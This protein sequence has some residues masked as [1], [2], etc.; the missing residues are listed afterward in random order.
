MVGFNIFSGSDWLKLFNK[1]LLAPMIGLSWIIYFIENIF[2]ALV[3]GF[4]DAKGNQMDI[5]DVILKGEAVQKIVLGLMIAGALLLFVFALIGLIKQYTNSREEANNKQVMA[6]AFKGFM[7]MLAIPLVVIGLVYLVNQFTNAMVIYMGADTTISLKGS[8]ANNLFVAL[9]KWNN[10]SAVD[11]SMNIDVL[12]EQCYVEPASLTNYQWLIGYFVAFILFFN[13]GKSTL[14]VGKRVFDIALLYSAAPLTASAYPIDKGARWSSWLNIFISKLLTTFALVICYFV[15]IALA[16][17]LRTSLDVEHATISFIL[18]DGKLSDE[19]IRYVIYIIILLTGGLAIGNAPTLIANLISDQAGRMMGE[20]TA[21]IDSDI[22]AGTAF[23]GATG[24]LGFKLGKSIVNNS[25]QGL[26][27]R[28]STGALRSGNFEKAAIYASKA[29]AI[30]THRT[31]ELQAVSKLRNA[32][33]CDKLRDQLYKTDSHGNKTLKSNAELHKTFGSYEKTQEALS[34]YRKYSGDASF[35]HNLS[36][37]GRIN[38]A[39]ASKFDKKY[40]DYMAHKQAQ[41]EHDFK[42]TKNGKNSSR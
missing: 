26:N 39:T 24:V 33:V 35:G 32:E 9:G 41:I 31:A 18:V 10:A 42:E 1:I 6:D 16:K 8:I 30:K 28:L 14:L 34:K 2:W 17:V 12:V 11:F 7:L 13:L 21:A 40:N 22:K 25:R 5:V 23:A 3:V 20:D 4:R 36:S 37:G 38:E 27:S 15:Y 19:T 29:A